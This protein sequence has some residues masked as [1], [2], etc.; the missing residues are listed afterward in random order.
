[1]RTMARAFGDRATAKVDL[2][3]GLSLF[4]ADRLRTTHI[5]NHGARAAVL[6]RPW[7]PNLLP[8]Q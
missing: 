5:G 7:S 8:L 3:A 1:M 4:D 6:A 2:E